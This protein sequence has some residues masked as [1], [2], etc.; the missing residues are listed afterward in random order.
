MKRLTLLMFS[1]IL[2]PFPALAKD[3]QDEL[4]ACRANMGNFARALSPA[5]AAR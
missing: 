1:A 2:I 5:K 3:D 4:S